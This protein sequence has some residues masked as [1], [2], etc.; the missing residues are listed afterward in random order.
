MFERN[1]LAVIFTAFLKLPC[2]CRQEELN[3]FAKKFR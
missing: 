3:S 1:S 2:L